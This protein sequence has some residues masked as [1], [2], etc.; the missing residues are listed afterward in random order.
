V[1]EFKEAAGKHDG[2]YFTALSG[3]LQVLLVW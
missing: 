3:E 1:S 2:K